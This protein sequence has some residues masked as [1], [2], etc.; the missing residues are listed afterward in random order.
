MD[1]LQFLIVIVITGI[2]GAIAEWIIGYKPGGILISIIIGIVG[3]AIGSWINIIVPLTIPLTII[4]IGTIKIN[5]IWTILGSLTLLITIHTLRD[6][7]NLLRR[8]LLKR[9]S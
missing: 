8:R 4:A 6:S 5:L 1:F 3:A 9:R 7:R 2:C